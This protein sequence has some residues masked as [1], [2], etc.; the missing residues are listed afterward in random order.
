MFEYV[1]I[2]IFQ[3]LGV[4][5]FLWKNVSIFEFEYLNTWDAQPTYRLPSI[6]GH[7]LPTKDGLMR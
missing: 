5:T 1:A 2:K 4:D 6:E 3:Y 7:L